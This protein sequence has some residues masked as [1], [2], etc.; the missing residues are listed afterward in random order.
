M[1]E[2]SATAARVWVWDER[3]GASGLARV[4]AVGNAANE[5]G[6]GYREA[7]AASFIA[8]QDAVIV[9]GR[10]EGSW[11]AAREGER[12][13]SDET[14][15]AASDQ[16]RPWTLYAAGTA[17]TGVADHRSVL[18]RWRRAGLLWELHSASASDREKLDSSARDSDAGLLSRDER[19]NAAIAEGCRVYCVSVFHLEPIAMQRCGTAALMRQQQQAQAAPAIAVMLAADPMLRRVART[20]VRAVYAAG[21]DLADVFIALSGEGK[22]AALAISRPSR[23]GGRLAGIWRDAIGAFDAQYAVM[24]ASAPA[25]ILIGADPEFVL[26]RADGRIAP[27]DRYLGRMG[28]AGADALLVRNRLM[29]PIGELRPDPSPTPEGLARS[30][31]HQL[32]RANERVK[33]RTL[34][35]AAGAMPLPG[36]ALGGHVHVSGAALTSRILRQLDRY[37]ALPMAMVE[38]ERGQARRPRYGLLGDFRRQAHGGFEYRTLPSWLVSPA[39]AK[40]SFALLLLCA[41][42]TWRLPYRP[43]LDEQAEAAFYAGDRSMLVNELD[44]ITSELAAA[45]SYAQYFRLIEPLFEAAH[46]GSVWN[47]DADIRIKWR[48][49]PLA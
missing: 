12:G 32:A 19:I 16:N 14:G 26:L 7:N 8:Q 43:A 34:R 36:I 13:W 33:D 5:Q 40:A 39:A 24:R 21:L 17:G 20:A 18:R 15:K 25:Q 37:L 2:G 22:T 38:H 23:E 45:P 49:G 1:R 42:D 47:E 6:S 35:W 29:Y 30:V 48:V 9:L 27:A 11:L 28:G 4:D 31:R 3:A 41:Q 10:G 44:S 46:R